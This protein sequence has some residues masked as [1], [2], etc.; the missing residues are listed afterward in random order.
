MQYTGHIEHGAI[1]LDQ[2]VALP[3]GA[4]V[5]IEIAADG[6]RLHPAVQR[7]T[8]ILPPDLDVRETHVREMIEKHQ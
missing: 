5:T 8:G 3:E 7:F 2:H 1:V 4:K 6:P